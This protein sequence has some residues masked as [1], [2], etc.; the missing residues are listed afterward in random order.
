MYFFSLLKKFIIGGLFLSTFYMVCT[1]MS[2]AISLTPSV[3]LVNQGNIQGYYDNN[4]A[5]FKGIPYAAPPTGASRWFPPQSPLTWNGIKKTTE[6][7]PN[8]SQYP[9]SWDNNK[10]FKKNNE[11]CLYLNIWMPKHYF[12]HPESQ[13]KYPVMI[14]LHGGG[15]VAGGSSLDI[16]DGAKLAQ[17]GVIVITLNYR[18][19]RFGF[20][21]HPALQKENE[22]NRWANYGIMDQIAALQW[23]QKN[24]ASFGGDNN[25]ITLFG[26]SAGGA[27]IITLMTISEAK[28]LFNKAIIQSGSGHSRFFPPQSIQQ[29]EKD[30]LKFADKYHIPN[31]DK[32]L[33]QLRQLPSEAVLDK[34]N[35]ENLQSSNFSGLIIDGIMLKQSLDKA[36]AKGE[37]YPVPTLIGDT[38]GD[39]F[40]ISSTTL[41][42]IANQLGLSLTDINKV[43]NPDGKQSETRIVYQLMADIQIL[44]PNRL[45][46]QQLANKNV[47]VYRYRFSYIATPAR[48]YTSYGAPHAS[49]NPYVFNTLPK[50]YASLTPQDQAMAEAVQNYWVNFAKTSVPYVTGLP[51]FPEYKTNPKALLHF[52]NKGIFFEEDPFTTRLDY[53]EQATKTHMNKSTQ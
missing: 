10:T 36:F 37:F 45:L 9:N 50:V 52:T 25:N 40:F 26:E 8:C 6:F 18:L 11:D 43:Y 44:E 14:W 4:L 3:S 31:N 5:I 38:N 28:G 22:E 12:E 41:P 17:Q 46:A 34:L 27:S 15:F 21:A 35:L 39:G 29:A 7:A 48:P 42:S 51:E 47:P 2:F 33:E 49:E 53:I 19:G 13:N 20:F 23:V 30:G 32:A 24:I 16:Y 1:P